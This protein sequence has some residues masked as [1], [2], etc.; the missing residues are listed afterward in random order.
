MYII[1]IALLIFLLIP[2]A[3]SRALGS[4]SLSPELSRALHQASYHATIEDDT[5]LMRLDKEGALRLLLTSRKECVRFSM[6]DIEGARK[7]ILSQLD[8]SSERLDFSPWTN[9]SARIL[10]YIREGRPPNHHEVLALAYIRA[11]PGWS[12]IFELCQG[13]AVRLGLSHLSI[14]DKKG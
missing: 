8:L 11:V 12:E 2:L 3:N 10:A 14:H 13:E 9:I 1:N 4:L 5:E 6:E 7:V